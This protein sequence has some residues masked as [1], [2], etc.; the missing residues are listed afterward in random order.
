MIRKKIATVMLMA[1]LVCT[2]FSASV[3]PAYADSQS[4]IG[5][6]QLFPYGFAPLGWTECTGQTMAI[7]TNTALFSLIGTYFGGNGTTTFALP[8]MRG[9]EPT[10]NMSYYIEMQGI[11]P[12]R[13][14]GGN[15]DYIGEIKLFPY[16]F[17]PSGYIHCDGRLLSIAQYD[18]LFAL[19]G[20]TYGGDG[21]T[22]FALPD[23]RSMEPNQYTRYCIN[24]MGVF[25]SQN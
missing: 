18:T 10:K 4:F 5:E 6:I 1:L 25:P 24:P 21:M 2:A 9:M 8:D 3:T 17:D 7:Q 15:T 16:N 20:T 14:G 19:I 23:M 13:D 22:T 12:V 11:F